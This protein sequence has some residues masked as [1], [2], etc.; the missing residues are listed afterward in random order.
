MKSKLKPV[1]SVKPVKPLHIPISNAPD[2]QTIDLLEQDIAARERFRIRQY[3]IVVRVY[4][5]E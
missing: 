5:P 1:K 3:G 2:F 4:N